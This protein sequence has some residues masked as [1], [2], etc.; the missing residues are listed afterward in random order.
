MTGRIR[1]PR[2]IWGY[3]D[4]M[5]KDKKGKASVVVSLN[6]NWFR[7]S[8]VRLHMRRSCGINQM[9]N[10]KRISVENSIYVVCERPFGLPE[11]FPTCSVPDNVTDYQQVSCWV[12]VV[13]G[14]PA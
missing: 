10:H 7:C 2:Q 5:L 6:A 12:D 9:Q 4:V 8:A 3:T 14:N 11:T 1:M 13:K